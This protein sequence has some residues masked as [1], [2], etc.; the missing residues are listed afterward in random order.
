MTVLTDRRVC[1]HT[2]KYFEVRGLLT[3]EA[4][5]PRGTVGLARK[6]AKLGLLWRLFLKATS[7]LSTFSRIP[8]YIG[9]EIGTY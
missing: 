4:F 7:S 3:L 6:A 2:I 1:T 5:S 9:H 8:A